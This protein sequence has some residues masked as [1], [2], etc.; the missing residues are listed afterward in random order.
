MGQDVQ[1]SPEG[2]K[3]AAG[4]FILVEELGESNVHPHC[5]HERQHLAAPQLALHDNTSV[6]RRTNPQLVPLARALILMQ[7]DL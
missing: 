6:A 2:Y 7:P 5:A 3:V 4:A 1:S